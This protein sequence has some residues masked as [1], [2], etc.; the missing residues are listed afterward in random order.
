MTPPKVQEQHAKVGAS[1]LLTQQR[2]SQSCLVISCYNPQDLQI[3]VTPELSIYIRKA[4]PPS[5]LAI[6]AT[7]RSGNCQ[8]VHCQVA[9]HHAIAVLHQLTSLNSEEVKCMLQYER[10]RACL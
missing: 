3:L 4:L 8:A 7:A 2:S 1:R 5:Q 9:G 6:Q 10:A